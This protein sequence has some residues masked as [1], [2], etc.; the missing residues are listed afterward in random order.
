MRALGRNDADLAI[1]YA[2]AGPMPH[3]SG[4][5]GRY[6]FLRI[7]PSSPATLYPCRQG[8]CAH[9]ASFPLKEPSR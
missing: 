6:V 2:I 5:R 8:R 3:F 7:L 1:R 4:P 9:F